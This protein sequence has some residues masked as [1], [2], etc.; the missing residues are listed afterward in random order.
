MDVIMALPLLVPNQ[1]SE[2]VPEAGSIIAGKY[3][4]ERL[5]R[6]TEMSLV[7]VAQH[8][9]L[10]ER[11]VVKML[12][13]HLTLTGEILERFLR[14]ARAASRLS[15]EHVARVIDVDTSEGGVPFMVMEYLKGRDLDEVVVAEGPLGITRAV[16]AILQACEAIAEAHT[17]GIIHRDLKPANLFLT[18]RS[19]GTPLVKVLDFG[20]SLMKPQ[21]GETGRR[22]TATQTIM[23]TPC[24]MS[25]E[26]LQ[27]TRNVDERTDIWSLGVMLHELLTGSSPFDAGTMPQ[28][29]ANVLKEAPKPLREIRSDVPA[30]LEKVVLRCL[31][32]DRARRYLTIAD[33]AVALTP[34]GTK[35]A[36]R[37]KELILRRLR[38]SGHFPRLELLEQKGGLL[39]SIPRRSGVRFAALAAAALVCCGF[40]AHAGYRGGIPHDGVRFLSQA[41]LMQPAVSSE[42]TEFPRAAE[43]LRRMPW[44]NALHATSATS[45]R[46]ADTKG[47]DASVASRGSAPNSVNVAARS[48]HEF[49][50]AGD[51]A[52]INQTSEPTD[53]TDH[54]YGKDDTA[55]ESVVPQPDSARQAEAPRPIATNVSTRKAPTSPARATTAGLGLFEDR[56]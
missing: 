55:I 8:L 45:G 30:G 26:Q 7:V 56:K 4:V 47:T 18:Q 44:M 1:I 52:R 25:P 10:D 15:T 36:V 29:C 54:P 27:S 28:V 49:V 16:D 41:N 31:E 46:A 42:P 23:G 53:D 13:P 32:K 35:D 51:L 37:S 3:R 11:V 9:R 14:E 20:I 22:I 40:A 2:G 5:L 39:A 43:P 6:T 12:P 48:T 24:Y 17:L 34:F 38:A 33:L 19:D 50:A 21:V